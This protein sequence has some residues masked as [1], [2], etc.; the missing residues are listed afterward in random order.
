MGGHLKLPAYGKA[1]VAKLNWGNPPDFIYV[2]VGGDA[3]RSAQNHNKQHDISALV[4][5]QRQDPAELHWP[6]NGIPVIVEWDG[7]AP[8][9][10]IQ[11][12]AKSLLKSGALKVVIYPTWVDYTAPAYC[13]DIAKQSFV[14]LRETLRVYGRRASHV[15]A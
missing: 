13:F 11:T 4:L 3:F 9:E 5:T 10:L 12:L 8:G 2:C 6:V 14:Q 7:S 15:H 1:L